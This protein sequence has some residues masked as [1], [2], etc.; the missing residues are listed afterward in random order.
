MSA[1]SLEYPDAL[2]AI[3]D[4]YARGWTDGLPIVPPTPDR[5]EALLACVAYRPDE[6]LARTAPNNRACTVEK[7]AIN[8]VMA[9]CLPE[10]F[11]VLV[12]ALEAAAELSR[13]QP[14]W[15]ILNA[16]TTGQAPFYVVNGPVRKRLGMSGAVNVFGPG[17][18]ANMT[19]GRAIRLILIN[20]FELRP[21]LF[22]MSSQGQPGKLALCIAENEEESPWTPFHVDRGFSAEDDTLTYMS[23]RG[24]HP[25]EN[26][27]SQEPEQILRTFTDLMASLALVATPTSP[28]PKVIVMGPEHAQLIAARGWSKDDVKRFVYENARRSLAD[29]EAVSRPPVRSAPAAPAASRWDTIKANP[30]R[31]VRN[32]DGVEY[33]YEHESPADVLLVVAGAPNAGTSAI[34]PLGAGRY[35]GGGIELPGGGVIT[36]RID[37]SRLP[38]SPPPKAAA[39]GGGADLDRA[40]EPIATALAADGYELSARMAEGRVAVSIIAGPGACADCLVP[41]SLMEGMIG[42]ALVEAGVGAAPIDLGYPNEP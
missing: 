22:D 7:A 21:G 25:V 5:V 4:Y 3:D 2:A 29:W 20:V 9:G 38:G 35:M 39:N 30:R 28:R 27:S 1:E 12:A 13:N 17:N 42:S 33:I 31:M 32:V 23:A 14:F 34:V 10:H 11:P 40:L 26:R 8:A 19:I 18:R 41:K 15:Y 36:K 37:L 24:T 6:V 16:S